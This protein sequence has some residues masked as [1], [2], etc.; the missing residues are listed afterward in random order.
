MACLTAKELI[1]SNIWLELCSK[2]MEFEIGYGEVTISSPPDG[3]R[4][5]ERGVALLLFLAIYVNDSWE[6]LIEEIEH[7]SKTYPQIKNLSFCKTHIECCVFIEQNMG[8]ITTD[9]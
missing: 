9:G 3:P 6:R 4:S 5:A 1:A 8:S 7:L 2:H